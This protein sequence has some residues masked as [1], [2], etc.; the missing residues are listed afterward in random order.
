MCRRRWAFAYLSD[1]RGPEVRTA[2]AGKMVHALL[3]SCGDQEPHDV[4]IWDEYDIA[5]MARALW[6]HNPRDDG[7][8]FE[9]EWTKILLG[10]VFKGIIDRL[11]G[12]Y[13]LDYKTTG[14][15]LRYA[16]TPSKLKKDVQRL[17]YSQA[18][19]DVP[20]ALWITGTWANSEGAIRAGDVIPFET[21]ASLLARDEKRDN[22][23]FKLYVLSPAEEIAAV[24]PGTDPLSFP[25]PDN[26]FS[27]FDSPCKKFQP[28]GCPHYKTCHKSKLASALLPPPVESEPVPVGII[29]AIRAEVVIP[30]A[31]VAEPVN[32][33]GYLVENLYIDCLPLFG[34]DTPIMYAH[35]LI[36][37]AARE[38][39]H[40]KALEHVMLADYAKGGPMLAVELVAQL[41]SL[42]PVQHLFIESKLPMGRAVVE[43][44]MGHSHRVYRGIP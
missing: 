20:N 43:Q 42:A 14:G 41:E 35:V 31:V 34:T 22:E 13:V 36:D 33:P 9:V 21:Q 10:I 44:L 11:S 1:V 26:A 39:E 23:N 15:S 8:L 28:E 18:F 4:A 2:T 27:P 40:D 5:R 29:E 6:R 24:K 12:R 17:L 32:T 37:R 38:V 7:A 3:E 30:P 16:K 19:P 25:L